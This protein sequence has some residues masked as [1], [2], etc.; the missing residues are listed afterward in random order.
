[1]IRTG[2]RRLTSLAALLVDAP[3]DLIAQA[4]AAIEPADGG[5]RE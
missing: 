4:K 1:M 5:K 3:S 2:V